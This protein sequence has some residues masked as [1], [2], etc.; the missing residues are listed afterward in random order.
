MRK[1][2]IW[3]SLPLG[4]MVVLICLT[5][6]VLVFK[7]ELMDIFYPGQ[8]YNIRE[9]F[10]HETMRLHRWL[11]FSDRAVGRVIVGVST[12]SM[13]VILVTGV[14]R[15]FKNRRFSIRRG[16]TRARLYFDLHRVFGLYAALI[17]IVCALSGLMWSFEWYRMGV[18]SI[19][20]GSLSPTKEDIPWKIVYSIHT[21]AWGGILTKW[22]TFIAALV[23]ASLPITGY[24]L[25][26]KKKIKR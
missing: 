6:A 20:S 8:P 4:I 19:L 5:G 21:G 9:G 7:H 12:I 13:V 17:L 23:G 10:F 16:A 3:L 22:A 2:H 15:W 14:A 11:M 26:F 25:Y 18:A 24:I 1:L